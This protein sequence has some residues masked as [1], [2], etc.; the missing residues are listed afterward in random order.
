[1]IKIATKFE[2]N[3]PTWEEILSNLYT[4]HNHDPSHIITPN[5]GF[6]VGHAAREIKS[7]KNIL[8]KLGLSYAHSYINILNTPTFGAHKDLEDV[9]YW[10]VIGKTKWTIENKKSYILNEGDLIFVSKGTL[11]DIT[12]LGV[13]VGIS[14]NK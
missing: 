13:R 7:V 1:M 12:P 9:W 10:Q 4:T 8:K 14:M 5:P 11:H 3:L 6:F 2:L